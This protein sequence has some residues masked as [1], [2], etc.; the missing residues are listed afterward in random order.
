MDLDHNALVHVGAVVGVGVLRVVRVHGVGVV[1]AEHEAGC[2]RAVEVLVAGAD[3]LRDAVQHVVQEGGSRTLLGAGAHFLVIK[4]GGHVDGLGAAALQQALQDAEHALLVIQTAGGDELLVAAPDGGLLADAKE[5]VAAQ[6]LVFGHV[7]LGG[8]E[9]FQHAF[10][11]GTAQQGQHVDLL[12]EGGLVVHLTVH[13]DGHAGDEQQ[14]TVQC[15]QTGGDGVA[16]L[17][18]HAA[19][20]GQ[21]AVQPGGADHAAVA[22][23]V[24]A[25]VL[26]AH[27][28]FCVLLDAEAGGVRVGS[29]HVEAVALQPGAHAEGDDA[30]AVAAD[31]IVPAGLQLPLAAF[32]QLGEARLQQDL[33]DGCGGVVGGGVAVDEGKQLPDFGFDHKCEPPIGDLRKGRSKSED[34]TGPFK[35]F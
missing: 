27:V 11:G 20:H 30:G 7:Q 14:V 13:V 19:G 9:L 8:D 1:G 15:H 26:L 4:E 3:V 34:L 29:G 24:Q 16:V 28:K 2:H 17:H 32:Q 21:R 33:P 12:V 5:Q 35:Y 22:F 18:Q 25:G 23:G 31:E 10:L 6:D